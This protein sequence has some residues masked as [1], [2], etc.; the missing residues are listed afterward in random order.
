[1][2]VPFLDIPGQY[3]TMKNEIDATIQSV[4]DK[5]TFAG[6]P[7]VEQFEQ[8]FAAFC[9]VK[10]GIAVNSGTAALTLLLQAH[11]IGTSRCHP[12][13]SRR[14]E[15]AKEPDEVILPV[16]TFIAT[17]EAVSILGALP[18]FVDCEESSALIDVSK[19]EEKI[20]KKTKAIIPVHLYGQPADMQEI[21][22]IGKKN[23]L[24]VFEDA[25][26]AH[27]ATYAYQPSPQSSPLK[28]RGSICG[29]LANG[30]AFSFYPGKNL[31]AF[32][33][34]GA[35]TTNDDAVAHTTR[36]LRDHGQSSKYHHDMIGWNERMDGIQGAVLSIKL[37]YLTQWNE[38]RRSVAHAYHQQLQ[39]IGDIDFMEEKPQ[40]THAYHLLVIKTSKR[41][42]LQKYLH[43]NGI[44]TGI[45]YPVPLHL[46]K[47]YE[48]LGYKKGDFPVAEKLA[49]EILSLPIF[50]EMTKEQVEEVCTAIKKFF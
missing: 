19:I 10:H 24:L 14:T 7:F 48:N 32:G 17:A 28:G 23:N 12:E 50:P 18:V 27:G 16:N 4:I 43:A 15:S 29:S 34:A 44:Q 49:Q 6:G 2:P 1:M 21:L 31:G 8:E 9:G 40:R 41:D 45:H 26:Q 39:E 38:K 20:S 42:P 5:G 36:M 13:R 30:A 3:K 11:D 46:T 47:A 37:K 35:I 22:E 25:C 33:E